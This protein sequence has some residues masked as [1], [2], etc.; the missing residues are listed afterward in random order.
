MCLLD[1]RC[2]SIFLALSDYKREMRFAD[3]KP[4]PSKN[5]PYF[6]LL[7][8]TARSWNEKIASEEVNREGNREKM[9]EKEHKMMKIEH[10]Q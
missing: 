9:R 5:L 3:V 2:L 6:V 10:A 1:N 7:K 8:Q 4:R